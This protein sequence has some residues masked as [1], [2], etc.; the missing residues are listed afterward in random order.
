MLRSR[1]ERTLKLVLDGYE[2]YRIEMIRKV[3]NIIIGNVLFGGIIGLAIDVLSGG[4][5]YI[6]PQTIEAELVKEM[7]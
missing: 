5:Y 3:D 6:Y 4:M 2:T 7:H 1:K